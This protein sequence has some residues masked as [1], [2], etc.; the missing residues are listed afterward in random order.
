ML[1]SLAN[2]S[3]LIVGTILCALVSIP[4]FV[5]G[6]NPAPA[7]PSEVASFDTDSAAVKKLS[8]A[9]DFIAAGE[10]NDALDLLKQIV[11]QHG[12][13][14]LAVSPGRYVN[15]QA[16]CDLL[17]SNLPAEGLRVYRARIDPQARQWFEAGRSTGD[18]ELLLR[19]VRQAFASSYADDALL[20]LGDIAWERGEFSRARNYWRK[21]IPLATAP[22]QLPRVVSY[23]DSTLDPANIRARLV[24]CSFLTGNAIRGDWELESFAA[25]HP[26]AEGT[27]AGRTGNLVQLV[28]ELSATVRGNRLSRDDDEMST[29]AGSANRNKNWPHAVDVGA[30]AW[31]IVLPFPAF[32]PESAERQLQFYGNEPPR[33]FPVVFQN[34]VF[35]SDETSVYAWNVNKGEAAWSAD[36]TTVNPKKAYERA[37]IYRLPLEVGRGTAVY[38]TAGLPQYAPTVAQGRL[39]A[40]L[41]SLT[42]R[43]FGPDNASQQPSSYLVCLDLAKEGKPVWDPISADQIVSDKGS[44]MFEGAPI[45]ENDR[46]YVG[47]RRG[48]PQPQENIVC[49]DAVTG[50][51]LWNRKVCSGRAAFGD[52]VQEI[53]HQLLTLAD[54]RLFSCTNMGAVVA[55][56]ARDG[57]FLWGAS[58]LHVEAESLR[59]FN[60][61]QTHGPNPCL[62]YDGT[63][64]SAPTDAESVFAFDSETGLLKW[65]RPL[66]GHVHALLGAGQGR[67]IAAGDQL[68]GLDIDTG[69]VVWTVGSRDPEGFGYGRGLLAEEFVY[70]PTRDE[71]LVVNQSKGAI[72]RRIPLA[73]R[74]TSGGNLA[75][76]RG[77]LFIA[78]RDRLTAFSSTGGPPWKFREELAARWFDKR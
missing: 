59:A 17:L 8:A 66:P 49:L 69:Q 28:R 60:R 62:F 26:Q 42:N 30:P 72:H 9:R 45:V 13:R 38:K 53:N 21:L 73:T 40:R 32:L 57:S 34:H 23:P 19:V 52:D 16:Y 44:W 56:D 36:P 37:A 27:L 58:Y 50:R 5:R 20:L 75:M 12:E 47:L 41:G 14:V 43:R 1:Q 10:W 6:Q 11:E 65:Q 24:L 55:L 2:R 76:S 46:M 67:A 71:L 35:V 39:Y 31:S 68:W 78:G 18:E 4:E 77:V 61:R 7:E 51:L 54:D 70:W 22:G 15:V 74:Q 64:I 3:R 25:L 33:H 29:F 63:L 48:S